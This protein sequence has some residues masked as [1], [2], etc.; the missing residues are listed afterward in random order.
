MMPEWLKQG[1]APGPCPCCTLPAPGRKGVVERTLGA[2]SG[3]FKESSCS[4][5]YSRRAGFLQSV[6]PRFKFVG[7]LFLVF[8]M[9][10]VTRIEWILGVLGLTLLLATASQVRLGSYLKRVWLFIPLFTAVVVLPATF[11]FVVPGEPLLVLLREGQ[12]VG[13]LTSP[14]TVAITAQG[15]SA[16]A[17]FVL[18]TGAAVSLMVLIA[19][20]TPWA[21]LLASLQSLK[22]PEA[23]VMLLGMTY[24]YVF[25]LVGIAQ[26][27]H[28][29]LKSRTMG[30]P[31]RGELV[32]W[33][34]GII[35]VLLRRSF[36]TAERVSLAMV[37]RGYD[38]RARSTARFRSTPF[39]WAF[40]C[41]LLALGVLLLLV[42][43][44]AVV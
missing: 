20:T 23:F 9:M 15:V 2:F 4:E 13:P 16:A 30:D 25:L 19:M 17:L 24:R 31:T 6:D 36:D 11:S 21:D 43:G 14:W 40:L 41:F 5:G 34:C 44:L 35:G 1:Q 42:R 22:V 10:F 12:A 28:F 7:A 39:D 38:G 27:M 33:L 26:E 3:F 32:K 18:R 8:C 29:A 37:S